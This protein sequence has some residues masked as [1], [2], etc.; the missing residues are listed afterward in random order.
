MK[1][2]L[3]AIFLLAVSADAHEQPKSFDPVGAMA[4][5]E[6]MRAERQ[7]RKVEQRMNELKIEEQELKLKLLRLELAENES[8]AAKKCSQ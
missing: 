4:E 7:A 5:G 2:L 8:E 1:I 6:R 3:I